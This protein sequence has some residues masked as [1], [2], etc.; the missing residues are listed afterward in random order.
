MK[1][2]MFKLVL[3]KAEEPEIKLPT[4]AGSSKKQEN[5]RVTSTSASLTMLKSLTTW[6]T[7][8]CGK[9][10]KRREYQTIS[11]AIL[12]NLYTGQEE[13]DRAGH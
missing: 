6:I 10:L 2:Q 9:F 3:G 5:S 11:P 4:S 12:R 8:N 1:F 13:T 7:T